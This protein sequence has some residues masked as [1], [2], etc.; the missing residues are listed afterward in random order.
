MTKLKVLQCNTDNLRHGWEYLSPKVTSVDLLFLQRFPK[1]K[2]PEL[3]DAIDGRVFMVQCCPPHDLCLA[4][5]RSRHAPSF[6]STETI[7]LPSAAHVMNMDDSFQGCT[8]LKTSMGVTNVISFMPCYPISGVEYPIT[9]TDRI[10]DIAFLLEKF[11]DEP[12][13]IAGDFHVDNTCE[14]T[15][16]LLSKYG[17]KSYLDEYETFYTGNDNYINLD[18]LVSNIDISISD[19]NVHKVS[20]DRGHFAIS[21]ELEFDKKAVD[22]HSDI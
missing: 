8:A 6:S 18:K 9:D 3:C 5:G 20:T 17:F 15:N 13:I 21:Y 19:V 2:R 4:I 12:T 22:N 16:E 10:T 7:V 11:K 14:T 1:E